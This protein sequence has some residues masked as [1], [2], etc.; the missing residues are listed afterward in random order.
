MEN[1]INLNEQGEI[2][3]F[4]SSETLEPGDSIVLIIRGR[5]VALQISVPG[6]SYYMISVTQA[7]SDKVKKGT[8]TFM[9]G[10]D[11]DYSESED[12][13]VETGGAVKIENREFSTGDIEVDWV[14]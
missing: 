12:F 11:V 5:K 6:T 10:E 2:Y 4:I 14:F 9:D 7:S 3:R 8:A 1:I 13:I